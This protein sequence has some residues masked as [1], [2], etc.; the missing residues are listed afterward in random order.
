MMQ[1][2]EGQN[3]LNVGCYLEVVENQKLVW[4]VA[5]KPGYRPA[6]EDDFHMS[7]VLL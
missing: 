7:L 4:T 6:V 5:L 3:F 1:S 2:P